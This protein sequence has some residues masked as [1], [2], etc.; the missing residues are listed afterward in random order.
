MRPS[1]R[2][3]R[4]RRRGPSDGELGSRDGAGLAHMF[5]NEPEVSVESVDGFLVHSP[6]IFAATRQ[7]AVLTRHG[8]VGYVTVSVPFDVTLVETLRERSGLA[9][10]DALVIVRDGRIVASSPTVRGTVIAPAGQMKTVSVGSE[11]FRALVAPAVADG[12]SV[13]FAVLSPQALIDAANSSSRNRLL[14]GLI[15][16]L[17]L[18][19]LVA[20][21]EGRSI[22]RM[23]RGS[24]RGPR[25]RARPARRARP[26]AR[27]RRVRHARE[28]VQ[29]HGESARGATRRARV[30]TRD[31]CGT[32]SPDS[33]R[34]SRR[35][36][37][38]ISS[39][40]SSSRPQ[41]RRRA[42]TARDVLASDG[43]PRARPAIPEAE[44]ERSSF[45]LDR[46][47]DGVRHAH[48]RR[49]GLRHGAAADGRLARR[50]GVRS[51]SRT[52]GCTGSSSGRRSSTA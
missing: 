27:P 12:L 21:C 28:C 30:R 15:V 44:G 17:V 37:T 13:R 45:G 3:R 42:P 36:T 49:R 16:S 2:R 33:A 39:C 10:A 32:Q 46:G 6:P 24:P 5:R 7:A 51:R 50:A 26:R 18:V 40:A 31:G 52:H 43:D 34:R 41:S 8:L 48:G 19:S 47:P 14:L 4:S 1:T 20:Y 9:R 29:R 25:D 35:R 23:L 11:P 22:V 38:S